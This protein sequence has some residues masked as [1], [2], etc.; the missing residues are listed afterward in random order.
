MDGS[1]LGNPGPAGWAWVIDAEQW[2]AGGWESG[3][4]NLGELTAI[5]KI[6]EAT[7]EAGLADEP[8]LLLADS[9]YAI[10]VVSKWRLGWKKRGWTKADKKPI[11][12]LELIQDID[13]AIEGRDVS[14]EWVKG[15]AGHELNELAD[16]YARACAE[17]YR[18]GSTIPSGPG[19]H[20][21]SLKTS[22]N[23]A[24]SSEAS[25]FIA[26]SSGEHSTADTRSLSPSS[27]APLSTEHSPQIPADT[28]LTVSPL[29][30]VPTGE[31]STHP[32]HAEKHPAAQPDTTTAVNAEDV[33]HAERA[34]ITAWVSGD[35]SA[36]TA[37]SA[38]HVIRIWPDGHVTR[39]L[40]GPLPANLTVGAI[41]PSEVAPGI[42]TTHYRLTW[43]GGTSLESSLWTFPPIHEDGP[44]PSG[45]ASS[46]LL[47]VQ[48][49]STL[50]RGDSEE[51]GEEPASQ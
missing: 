33:I 31:A 29:Q 46:P 9:Q 45:Q 14:F 37:M 47:L 21:P 40:S 10:N 13:R 2:D 41:V 6:L 5:L 12:N 25:A 43:D 24:T 32:A 36:L 35:D 26:P 28:P 1:S 8:L 27:T 30:S 34:F 39:H 16:Q 20:S 51:R 42:W 38:E 22:K 17:A 15:H 11:K 49:Q 48:H 23:H 3:T 18:Q 44:H 4:N 7:E 50:R 19:I